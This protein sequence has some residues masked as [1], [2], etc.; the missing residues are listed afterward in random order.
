MNK[1]MISNEINMGKRYKQA[2][3][4]ERKLNSKNMKI[5]FA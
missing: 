5:I 4:R 3:Y 2:Y 1:K